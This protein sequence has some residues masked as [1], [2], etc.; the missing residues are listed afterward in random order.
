MIYNYNRTILSLQKEKSRLEK[1]TK[2]AK[3]KSKSIKNELSYSR[4]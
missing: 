1:Q 4:K 2:D 3:K